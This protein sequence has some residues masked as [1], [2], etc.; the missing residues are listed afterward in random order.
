MV[1]FLFQNNVKKHLLNEIHNHRLFRNTLVLII[2]CGV[3]LYEDFL[4]EI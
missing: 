3:Y 1:Q 4:V 2:L